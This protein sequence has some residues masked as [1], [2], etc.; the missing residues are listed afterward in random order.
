MPETIQY[1][2]RSFDRQQMIR[3]ARLGDRSRPILHRVFSEN[4]VFLT[5]LLTDILGHGPSAIATADIP[6]LHHFHGRGAKDVIPL[7]RDAD[8][9]QPNVTADILDALAEEYGAPVSAERLFAYAYGI[10][11]QPDY[12]RRFWDE[13]EMPPPRLPIT[14]DAA[15]FNEV[16]DHGARLLYL[17]TWGERYQSENDDGYVP[18]GA[19]RCTA[20]VS[21]D[22]YP[23]DHEYDAAIQTL[24]VGDGEFA[25]VAPEVWEFSVSGYQ[26]VRSWLD[27][28]KLEPSG[29]KSSP[30]DRIRPERWDFTQELLE[31]IW[32]LEG[33]PCNARGRGGAAQSRLRRSAILRR[34][35]SHASTRRAPAA[36]PQRSAGGAPDHDLNARF[37]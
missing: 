7:Y 16:A 14:R 35:P 8:A 2:Y 18:Q 6:D 10:L 30:L 34:R 21:L 17:H 24:R 3:D 1:A 32:I 27:R 25:P 26:V 37:A 4:Q 5:S 31:L 33:D 29:R 12:V 22:D 20:P 28:R 13:L 19:A 23:A 11:A 9:T 36:N 15:L